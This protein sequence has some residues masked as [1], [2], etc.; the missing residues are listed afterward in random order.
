MTNIKNWTAYWRNTLA[1]GERNEI[2]PSS[3]DIRKV[4]FL[5]PDQISIDSGNIDKA[6]VT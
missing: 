2:D 5:K 6:I 4:L 1:D 3:I